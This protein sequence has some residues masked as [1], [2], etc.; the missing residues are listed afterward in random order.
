MINVKQIVG[1]GWDV[2]Q[3]RI[4]SNHCYSLMLIVANIIQ[5]IQSLFHLFHSQKLQRK[6]KEGEINRG[7]DDKREREREG[8]KEG[9]EEREKEE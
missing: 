9:K 3:I 5:S 4:L 8:E 2:K 7:K 1:M 6:E